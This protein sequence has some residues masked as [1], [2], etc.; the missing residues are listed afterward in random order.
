M[1]KN[2]LRRPGGR[3]YPHRF[4]GFQLCD[5]RYRQLRHDGYTGCRR[6]GR[7]NRHYSYQSDEEQFETGAQR[8]RD[9]LDLAEEFYK[10]RVYPA[11]EANFI[12]AKQ[13]YETEGLTSTINYSKVHADLGLLYAT[14][15]RFSTAEEY[16]TEALTL[17]E[18]TVGKNSKAYASSLNNRGVLMQELARYNESEKNF[19]EALKV[20]ERRIGV[21]SQ[22]YA[23]AL[24]NQ[25]ILYAEIGRFNEAVENLKKASAILD[26]L[27]K[28]SLRQQVG[29]QSNLALLYQQTGR[30]TEAE[31]IYLN[32]EKILGNQNPYYAGVLNNLALLYIQMGKLDKV[33]NY[34][35]TSANVY[36][37]K[38]GDKNPNYAKVL[39]DLGNF[40][41][42]QSR[43]DDAEKSL[44][45]SLTIRG[46]HW[47]KAIRTMCGRR[48]ILESCTGKRAISQ[49]LE[50]SIRW[51]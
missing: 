12:L 44:N 17:R 8:S 40:Y 29:F 9:F 47:T 3:T 2:R 23:V 33:E 50:S 13:S 45:L 38:F 41:R 30:F 18:K 32:L 43:F 14:M 11:A 26:K 16:T 25:A 37:T 10:K 31:T 24:N 19:A 4:I 28:K 36:K 34:L 51:R 21:E 46:L 22:E 27:K 48:R 15:G 42:M 5:F 20:I 7:Q 49:K 6:S 39:N 1:E 35:Q